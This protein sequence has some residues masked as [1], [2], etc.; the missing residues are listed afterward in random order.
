MRIPQRDDLREVSG[1]TPDEIARWLKLGLL[2]YMFEGHGRHAFPGVENFIEQQGGSIADDLAAIVK[3]LGA[4]DQETFRS[5][6]AIVLRSLDFGDERDAIFAK[7]LL[8]LG[9]QVRALGLLRVLAE[10][11]FRISD[12]EHTRS[13][14]ELAF[15]VARDLSDLRSP[16]AADCL[17]HLIRCSG[18]FRPAL[19]GRALVALTEADPENFAKHYDRLYGELDESYGYDP[20]ELHDPVKQEERQELL[21]DIIAILPNQKLLLHPCRPGPGPRPE[22]TNWWLNTLKDEFRTTY[23][24]LLG[25]AQLLPGVASAVVTAPKQA[26]QRRR[27]VSGREGFDPSQ[28]DFFKQVE[29]A[30]GLTDPVTISDFQSLDE[31]RAGASL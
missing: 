23:N 11:A 18:F 8:R 14:Y 22:V 7:E 10:K 6:C 17:Y 12:G 15:E 28:L 24:F 30:L 3:E 4:R 21:E 26:R 5:A 9:A 16:D 13:L 29:N 27:R 2:E 1:K 25:E 31:I 20:V 19:A